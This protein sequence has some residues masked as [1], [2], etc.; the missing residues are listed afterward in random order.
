MKKKKKIPFI[1]TLEIIIVTV[2]VISFAIMIY[3]IYLSAVGD[4]I[5]AKDDNNMYDAQKTA[6]NAI[7]EEVNISEV[8]EEINHSVV[9]I[10][11]VKNKGN[12]VF[13]EDGV[14]SLGLGT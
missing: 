3:C 7:A 1:K 2:L 6:T 12:T 14:E 9:G 13:L 5:F 8:I 10:S 11:K 4:K